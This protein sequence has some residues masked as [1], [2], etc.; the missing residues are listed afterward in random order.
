MSRPLTSIA[1]AALDPVRTALR[2]AAHADAA[3]ALR[4]A[5]QRKDELLA[6]ARRTAEEMLAT[7]RADG[8]A[9][10]TAVVNTRLAQSRRDARRSVLEAQRDLYDEL[11]QRCRVAATALAEGPGSEELRRHLAERAVA[12]LGSDVT[13]TDCADGGVLASAGDRQLDLTLPTLAER[14]LERSGAE[15]AQLW[16]A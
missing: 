9:E 12:Q 4:K 1:D 5:R 13:V 16:R 3:E 8:E 7:A 6:D 15:V 11:Q 2:A 10:A 14:A